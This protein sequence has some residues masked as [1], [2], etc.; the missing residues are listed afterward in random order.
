MSESINH[1]IHPQSQHETLPSFPHAP[2]KWTPA[3]AEQ[4]AQQEGVRLNE[5]HLE[6]INAIQEYYSKHDKVIVRDLHD[7]LDEHFHSKGGV[8]YLYVLFPK[9]PVAQGCRLAGIQ[10]PAGSEDRSFG[11]VQ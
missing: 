11:S 5:D 6:A 1:Y 9:G 8:R 2:A 4:L 3:A 10:P 7:A